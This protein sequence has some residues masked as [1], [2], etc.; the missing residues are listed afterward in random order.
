MIGPGLAAFDTSLG[1]CAVAW[2]PAGLLGVALPEKDR[3]R[4]LAR[5]ERRHPEGSEAAPPP[6][7][8]VAIRRI[9]SL[10]EG[11]SGDDLRDIELDWGA[12]PPFDRQVYLAAR[13]VGPGATLTYG[14]LAARIGD[15]G[16]AR[17]VAGALGRNPFPIVVPCHRVLAANG[18]LGG[19]SAPGGGGTKVRLLQIERARAGPEPLLFDELSIAPAR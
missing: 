6:A 10:L 19:F 3:A 12:V 11:G 16:L 9:A 7:V 8:A 18:R 4:T 5:L 13:A 15:R 17:A 1:P 14:E 2:G